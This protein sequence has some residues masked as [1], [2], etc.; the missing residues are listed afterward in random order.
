MKRVIRASKY[1]DVIFEDE[2]FEFVRTQGVGINHTP[3][4]GLAVVSKG[5]AKKHVVE[6]RL[7]SRGWYD[8]DGTPVEFTYSGVE[9]A[10]GMR[11]TRD[12]LDETVEYIEV[13]EDALDFAYRVQDWLDANQ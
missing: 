11:S 1:N 2:N 7:E 10:H 5:L 4:T 3:W 12:T 13:L 6:I 9:V 8:Y